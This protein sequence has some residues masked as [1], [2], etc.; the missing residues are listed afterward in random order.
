MQ[1]PCKEPKPSCRSFDLLNILWDTPDLEEEWFP[2]QLQGNCRRPWPRWSALVP[3]W[4]AGGGSSA[5]EPPDEQSEVPGASSSHKW[6][7][8]DLGRTEQPRPKS[9]GMKGNLGRPSDQGMV[10]WFTQGGPPSFPVT[11]QLHLPFLVEWR[12]L[13]SEQKLGFLQQQPPKCPMLPPGQNC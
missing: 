12:T 5:R 6:G 10:R 8:W 3:A 7:W 4:S 11:G 13:V 1:G 9:H 2:G